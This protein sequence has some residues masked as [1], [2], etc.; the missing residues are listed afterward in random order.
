GPV[1]AF[2]EQH[3]AQPTAQAAIPVPQKRR[4]LA[5]QDHE[6][7]LDDVGGILS[8]QATAA[9]PRPQ[10]W[11]VATDQVGPSFFAAECG[12]SLRAARG[13]IGHGLQASTSRVGRNGPDS[14]V[15]L[16]A[17]AL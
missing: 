11:R 14:A 16:L 3:L 4:L 7:V 9:G 8:V 2:V 10:Q 12:R 1:A 5:H 15:E 13:N 6:Y 17:A